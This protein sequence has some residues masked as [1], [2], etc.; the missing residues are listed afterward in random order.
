[1][2]R[3]GSEGEP[4]LFRTQEGT[5]DVKSLQPLVRKLTPVKLPQ[6]PILYH[7]T[8]H[9]ACGRLYWSEATAT[10]CIHCDGPGAPVRLWAEQ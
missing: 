7:A 6:D 1:V 10:K 5:R 4:G 8:Y 9:A 2:N 3:P